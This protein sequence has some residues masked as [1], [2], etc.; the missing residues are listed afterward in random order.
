MERDDGEREEVMEAGW[1]RRK[2]NLR[3]QKQGRRQ[4]SQT[5]QT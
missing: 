5:R 1:K 3:G 2:N 4:M